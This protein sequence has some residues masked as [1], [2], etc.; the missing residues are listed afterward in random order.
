MP[1]QLADI[2]AHARRLG[3]WRFFRRR[4]RRAASLC[5]LVALQRSYQVV[6]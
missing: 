5:K 3:V 2:A 4:R 6:Y 1:P